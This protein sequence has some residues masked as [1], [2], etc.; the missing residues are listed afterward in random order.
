MAMLIGKFIVVNAYIKKEKISQI[1][2]LTLHIKLLV[3]EEQTKFNASRR[4]RIIKMRAEMN[5]IEK[6]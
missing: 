1:N 4:K 6:K 2:N 3:K 5:E